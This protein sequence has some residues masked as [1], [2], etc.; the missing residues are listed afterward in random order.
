MNYFIIIVE[1]EIKPEKTREFLPL[2]E[3][4]ALK[5]LKNETGC[6][7]FDVLTDK[8]KPNTFVLYEIYSDE[9]AFN[10]HVISKHFLDFDT[11]T[12][13]MI[14][15]KSVRALTPRFV[16]YAEKSKS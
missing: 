10:N 4:N 6:L 16:P 5:S 3:E 15:R 8:N 9:N 11:A 7:V 13:D 1:F 2:I 12:A 14:A